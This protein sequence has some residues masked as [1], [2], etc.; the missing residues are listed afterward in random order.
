MRGR[1]WYYFGEY[2]SKKFKGKKLSK[3]NWDILR[4]IY[5]DKNFAI[6][7]TVEKYEENCRCEESYREAAKILC[8]EFKHRKCKNVVSVGVGK[9][10]LEWH[11][12]N[13]KPDIKVTCTDYTEKALKKLS[14]VFRN[15]DAL[16]CFDM[17]KDD[18]SVL[19][20]YDY[21]ILYRVSTE[22]SFPEWR[23]I[24]EQMNEKHIKRI[25]FIPTGLD[26][27]KSMLIELYRHIIRTVLKKKDI[28]CGWLYSEN[29][30]RKMWEGQYREEKCIYLQNTAIFF[31]TR[32]E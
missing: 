25:I 10:I 30:F 26:T 20:G 3:G 31:L 5:M 15:V 8:D 7:D 21:V 2:Y 27:W 24:F 9:G 6:E 17:I 11:I 29:E 1:H 28:F 23:K 19:N 32:M 13:I 18:W 14:K 22:F 12:K 16:L 4:N